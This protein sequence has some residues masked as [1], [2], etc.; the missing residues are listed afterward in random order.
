MEAYLLLS[1]KRINKLGEAWHAFRTHKSGVC[2]NCLVIHSYDQ[3]LLRLQGNQKWANRKRAKELLSPG[4]INSSRNSKLKSKG[5]GQVSYC[6]LEF[7]E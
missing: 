6:F 4:K 7:S 3:V 2:L 5:K 1:R